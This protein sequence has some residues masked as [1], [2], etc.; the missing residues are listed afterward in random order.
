MARITLVNGR[1]Y[2]AGG[3]FFEQGVPQTVED[4]TLATHLAAQTTEDARGNLVRR[5]RVEG[6][7]VAPLVDDRPGIAATPDP[8]AD[9][10]VEKHEDRLGSASATDVIPENAGDM[11]LD[12]LRQ[13]QGN[14]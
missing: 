9:L 2:V 4:G 10:I 3:L 8:N 7:E 14:V 6:I 5:F 12:D 13:G 1:T 11:T